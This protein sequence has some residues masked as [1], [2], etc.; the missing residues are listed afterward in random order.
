[1][2]VLLKKHRFL[3]KDYLPMW[4]DSFYVSMLSSQYKQGK[5]NVLT[6]SLNGLRSN[7]HAISNAQNCSSVIYIVEKMSENSA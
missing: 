2:Q 3:I 6:A 4:Y 1:M 5:L 7:F